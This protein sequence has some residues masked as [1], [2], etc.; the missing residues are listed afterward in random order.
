M[1]TPLEGLR[2]IDQTQ[3]LAGPYC[4]M[5]LGD[6]GAEVIKIERPGVGD[7]SRQWAPPYLGDQSC[8]YLAMNRNKRGIALNIA[9]PAGQEV[10]HTMLKDADVFITNLATVETLNRYAI[11]YETLHALN[12]RLIYASISGYGRTGPRADQPGYD[13]V[14]QAESGTMA[15][16]G[17]VAAAPMRFPTPI[18]DMTCGLFTLVGILAALNARHHTGQGQCIDMSLQEGQMTWLLNYAG[19]YFADGQDPPRRG[20]RHPQV[21]PYEA[22]QGAEGEWFILGVASDNVW[23]AFCTYVGQPE[24]AADPRFVSNHLRIANY[25][26]L[27]PIMRGIIRQRPTEAWLTALRGVGVPCGRINTVKEALSD[28]HVIERGMIV[29]LEHPALG[30]VKSLATPIPLSDTPL[31]YYRH[32]PRLGEHTDEVLGE[33]G[34]DAERRAALRQRGV[35]A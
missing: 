28:P 20:N 3:A 18:A 10:L 2:V 5:M 25:E 16:T 8:Y 29:T 32:P 27:M 26:A 6:L 1:K 24:L 9:D 11:D 12:P 35:I 19:E 14:A 22:V 7:Q 23:Q 4:G 15:L 33:Y 34:I 31:V 17:E 30:L 21:V 13:L